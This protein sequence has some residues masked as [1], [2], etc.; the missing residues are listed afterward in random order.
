MKNQVGDAHPKQARKS[1]FASE[2]PSSKHQSS[3]VPPTSMGPVT[4]GELGG[5]QGR[6]VSGHAQ[7]LRRRRL[8]VVTAEARGT[9]A[10]A[11]RHVRERRAMLQEL[12]AMLA[13]PFPYA[14]EFYLFDKL[15]QLATP[16]QAFVDVEELLQHAANPAIVDRHRV[17]M[18]LSAGVRCGALGK[19]K[20]TP[21]YRGKYR[22]TSKGMSYLA[23]SKQMRLGLWEINPAM[24]I[25][26]VCAIVQLERG[27]ALAEMLV[28]NDTV[29]A[30]SVRRAATSMAHD[31]RGHAEGGGRGQVHPLWAGLLV[32]ASCPRRKPWLAASRHPETRQPSAN[33]HSCDAECM[34]P[35]AAAREQGVSVR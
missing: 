34:Q 17:G 4:A 21:G 11:L 14:T 5:G 2:H 6:E 25:A 26:E 32:Q 8:G 10:G 23:Q 22:V 20:P 1:H 33:G 30:Q 31:K 19:D 28:D 24:S 18:I 7:A 15:K 29:D 3:G 13:R 35:C 12:E 16:E 27:D 9:A